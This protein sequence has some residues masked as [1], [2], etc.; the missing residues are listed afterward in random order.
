MDG[1]IPLWKEKGMTSHDCVFKVRKILRM[2]KVGHGGTLDPNVD[3][4]LPICIGKGT[5][6]LDYLHEYPKTYFGKIKLGFS[7]TTEDSEGEIVCQKLLTEKISDEEI[8]QAMQKFIGK[9]IQ[10]P[11]MYSAVKVNGK[12]LY[13]YARAG[14]EVTR[15]KRDVEIYEFKRMGEV[16]FYDGYLEWPFLVKCS[17]GT[18]VRTLAYDLGVSLGYPAHMSQLTRLSSGGFETKEAITLA[19]LEEHAKND[20]LKPVIAPIERITSKFSGINLTTEEYKKVTNGVFLALDI[21]EPEVA[22]YYQKQ[23]VAIYKA[24]NGRYYPEKMF[25][26]DL[27]K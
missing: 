25:N 4:V 14:E 18:Y 23:C 15:P 19:D 1:I 11:P 22:L 12:R 5:K 8:D 17:K 24:K 20:N 7:T 10:I 21:E 26:L 27:L 2:K 13:E 9:I 3:G 16:E 6:L